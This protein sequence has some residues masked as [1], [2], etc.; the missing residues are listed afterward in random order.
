MIDQLRGR[1]ERVG[2]DH[3]IL[4]VGGV[5]FRVEMPIS[6]LARLPAPGR[7]AV[8]YTHLHVREDA[9]TLYGFTSAQEQEL[10]RLLL[11]VTGV[12]PRVALSL[13]SGMSP[14]ELR[15]AVVYEDVE[16][17]TGVPGVGT[18][19]A[20]R[21]V[22]ELR[23]ILGP[24]EARRRERR[25]VSA[26]EPRTVPAEALEA[27]VSLGYSR[28][29]ASRAVD[30]AARALGPE[31]TAEALVREGLKL[32]GGEAAGRRPSLPRQ[33]GSSRRRV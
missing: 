31:A 21:L 18:K 12:G 17:L 6:A 2:G 26:T 25:K 19:T 10:F 7:E 4:S 22:L 15:R 28:P 27:L 30:E 20:Q 23:E 11:G 9:L 1:V 32:L 5:G 24:R 16:S 13:L 33:P 8:L 14:E 29:E 3:V